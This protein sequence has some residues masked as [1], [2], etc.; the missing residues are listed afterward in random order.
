M[1]GRSVNSW[2]QADIDFSWEDI[3]NE[4]TM[5]IS[6]LHGEI[7]NLKKQMKDVM[8][9]K[10]AIFHERREAKDE[11]NYWRNRCFETERVLTRLIRYPKTER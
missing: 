6:R 1:E 11:T 7:D 3:A 4:K 8:E 9:R 5:E 10:N 2:K